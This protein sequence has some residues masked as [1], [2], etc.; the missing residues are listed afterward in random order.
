MTKLKIH[1]LLPFK[2][3]NKVVTKKLTCQGVVVRS[4]AVPGADDFNVAIYFND[5]SPRDSKTIS[6]YINSVVDQSVKKV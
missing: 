5:L 1:L 2:R 4:E 3:N 6:D